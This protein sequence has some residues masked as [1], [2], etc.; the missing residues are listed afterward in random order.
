MS[1]NEKQTLVPRLR[2]SEFC[3]DQ[4]WSFQALGKLAKRSTQK[5]AGGDITRVLTNSA[6]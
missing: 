4:P 3:D 5:N 2:F 6:E 1:G